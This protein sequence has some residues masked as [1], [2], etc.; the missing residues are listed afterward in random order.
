MSK[1]LFNGL[2]EGG[3]YQMKTS[4][5]MPI[6]NF[7]KILLDFDKMYESYQNA[8]SLFTVHGNDNIVVIADTHKL[9][10]SVDGIDFDDYDV[11]AENIEKLKQ[12]LNQSEISSESAAILIKMIENEDLSVSTIIEHIAQPGQSINID[13]TDTLYSNGSFTVT[14]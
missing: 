3:V 4:E 5:F 7:K 11:F 1:I 8:P 14:V 9:N 6:Q 13:C 2:E 12:H 10:I